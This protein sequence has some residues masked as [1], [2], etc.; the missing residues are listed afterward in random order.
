MRA[1]IKLYTELL[2]DPKVAKW[3]DWLFKRFIQLI[4]CAGIND[5]NGV[6]Q[7][8]PDLAW[9]C[10]LDD[11]QVLQTLLALSEAGVVSKT[12]TEEQENAVWTVTNFA[13]RQYSESYERVKRFREKRSGSVTE[14]L[15]ETLP[16]PVTVPLFSSSSL[17]LNGGE[18]KEKANGAAFRAYS[19]NFGAITPMIAE[20]VMEAIQEY[21]EAW[22]IAAIEASV[23]ANVRRW[24]YA[25]A[26][27]KRWRVEG[28]QTKGSE[29]GGKSLEQQGYKYAGT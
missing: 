22:V 27:L 11:D 25:E 2:L 28:F 29:N 13:K 15:Q 6:L 19:Q 7:P 10:R 20:A 9:L 4:L 14:T 1:W 12:D 5:Q 21:T 26:I 16:P 18:E 23:K 24:N 8:V 17:L 3:P